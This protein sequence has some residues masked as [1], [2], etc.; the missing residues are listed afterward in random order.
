MKCLVINEIN[1]TDYIT[2][3]EKLISIIFKSEKSFEKCIDFKYDNDFI[4]HL[5]ISDH[6]TND[7]IVGVVRY[8]K[9]RIIN[10]N[11]KKLTIQIKGN[12]KQFFN[13][14][15][16]KNLRKDKIGDLLDGVEDEK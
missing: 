5:Y 1:D 12:N 16:L 10:F 4:L 7:I 3:S 13:N 2:R 6:I 15:Q 14:S 8:E 11:E 9:C